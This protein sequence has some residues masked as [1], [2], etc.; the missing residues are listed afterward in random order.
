MV[1]YRN[2][3][4]EDN[5]RCQGKPPAD[6]VRYT[7]S[8]PVYST[9]TSGRSSMLPPGRVFSQASGASQMPQFHWNIGQVRWSVKHSRSEVILDSSALATHS[10]ATG[11]VHAE[12]CDELVI[13]VRD[14]GDSSNG[15]T[16]GAR[17]GLDNWRPRGASYW[18]A[19]SRACGSACVGGGRRW[20]ERRRDERSSTGGTKGGGVNGPC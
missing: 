2:S 7:L 13:V 1:E 5:Q 12:S 16:V 10:L 9:S 3:A 11:T 19:M 15:A 8:F 4:A 20:P 17:A 6:I 14:S 18:F